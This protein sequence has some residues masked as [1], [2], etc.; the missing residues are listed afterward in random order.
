MA[1]MVYVK[2][3]MY[4]RTEIC[5]FP[6]KTIAKAESI[7]RAFQEACDRSLQWHACPPPKVYRFPAGTQLQAQR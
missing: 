4:R 6:V 2:T 3:T 5:K 1:P 7:G